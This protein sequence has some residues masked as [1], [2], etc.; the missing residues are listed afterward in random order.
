MGYRKVRHCDFCSTD[1]DH[2]HVC[3]VC[4]ADY[5]SMCGQELYFLEIRLCKICLKI[6]LGHNKEII[7]LIK[8]HSS[9]MPGR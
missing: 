5:C 3:D 2:F 7:K 1:I 9:R 4:N 8:K 6:G